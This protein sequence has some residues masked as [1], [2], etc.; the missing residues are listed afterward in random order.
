MDM[1]FNKKS[2]AGIGAVAIAAVYGLVRW[3]SGAD[4]ASEEVTV[5]EEQVP[6]A[7]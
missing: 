4:D 6:A 7:D 3:Q 1:N 5:T 2:L